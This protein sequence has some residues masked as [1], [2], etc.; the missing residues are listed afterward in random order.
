MSGTSIFT[1]DALFVSAPEP[2]KWLTCKHILTESRHTSDA[3]YVTTLQGHRQV[4]QSGV[5]NT[6]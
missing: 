6:G 1:S 4:Q 3:A 2:G 5:D